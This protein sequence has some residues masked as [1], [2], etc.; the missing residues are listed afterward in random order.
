MAVL[1]KRRIGTLAAVIGG[2]LLVVA[3]AFVAV[4]IW[5]MNTHGVPPVKLAEV[6]PGMSAA[7][8]SLLGEPE[9]VC[10]Q[11]GGECW[12]YARMTWCMVEI[13]LSRGGEVTNIVH[14]H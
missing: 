11:G 6:R 8:E 10:E 9:S 12:K 1:V 14:D 7:D 3:S 2:L 13:H 4:A 5:C